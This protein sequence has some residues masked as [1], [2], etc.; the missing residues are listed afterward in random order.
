[1]LTINFYILENGIIKSN[2]G[3]VLAYLDRNAEMLHVN[4]DRR[5]YECD[6]DE[7]AS[8]ILAICLKTCGEAA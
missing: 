7:L 8:D 4:C 6:S 5:I 3:E 1:M 2:E